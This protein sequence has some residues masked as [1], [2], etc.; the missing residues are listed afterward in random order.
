MSRAQLQ[1]GFALVADAE[2]P[3]GG[4][5]TRALAGLG[6]GPVWA[7]A[8]DPFSVVPLARG[9]GGQIVPLWLDP[10]VGGQLNAARELTSGLSIIVDLGAESNE[11]GEARAIALASLLDTTA[12]SALVSIH[13]GPETPRRVSPGAFPSATHALS[14]TIDPNDVVGSGLATLARIRAVVD[15]LGLEDTR[16]NQDLSTRSVLHPSRRAA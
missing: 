6:L 3:L 4:V 11:R 10:Q 16:P 7:S 14:V 15:F 13:V 5:I 9:Q 8:A 12:P 1:G 2:R